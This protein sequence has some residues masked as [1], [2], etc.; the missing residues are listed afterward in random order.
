AAHGVGELL[1]SGWK[2]KRTLIYASW[3][4][5][6]EGLIGSTEWAEQHASELANAAAYFNMDVAV[7]GAK[8]GAS[9]VPSL[10]QFLR[11]VSKAVPSA[12]GGTVYEAW[13]KADEPSSP[14]TQSPTEAIGDSRRM[15][16]A[17]VKGEVPVGD[18]GSG[19]DYSAFLQHLG[20]PCTDVSST[21]SYGVYHSVVDN[22]AWFKKFGDPD[23]VYEQQMA[24]IFGLE[25]LRMADA[26]VL[27]YDYEQYG[28]EIT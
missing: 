21:G 8:F 27:P 17:P 26:D 22:F 13:E 1:K 7:P 2:P 23:F 19:S 14:S 18:L 25:V 12:K 24:R 28:K 20:I 10:K 6:E 16:A 3:D 9:A 15:P 5:E 4:G 11:D